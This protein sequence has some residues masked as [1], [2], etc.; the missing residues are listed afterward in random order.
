VQAR[1]RAWG[2]LP[3]RVVRSASL[4][5]TML[6]VAYL[7]RDG[8]RARP[9]GP[10]QRALLDPMIRRSDNDAADRIY[11]IVRRS[12][13]ERVARAAGMRTFAARPVFWGGS[14]T[15]ARDQAVLMRRVDA[16]LPPRHRSYAM[17]LLRDVVPSQR[18]GIARIVRPGW[19]VYSKPGWGSGPGAVTHQAALLVRGERRIAVAIATTD[20]PSHKEG[21][22]TLRGVAARLLRTLR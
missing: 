5:K 22:R 14:R 12:G 16:L 8:V 1:G 21:E 9:L 2:H 4:V 20:N 13:L 6:M 11:A 19:T 7:R 18:W 3:D 15:T 17:G 10:A